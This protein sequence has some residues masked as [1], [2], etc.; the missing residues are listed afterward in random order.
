MIYSYKLYSAL[1]TIFNL[2]ITVFKLNR[3]LQTNIQ[4]ETIFLTFFTILRTCIFC[5]MKSTLHQKNNQTHNLYVFLHLILS[6]KLNSTY[7]YF[8]QNDI[9]L[10]NKDSIKTLKILLNYNFFLTVVPLLFDSLDG[11]AWPFWLSGLTCL[12]NSGNFKR[13]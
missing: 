13:H 10:T 12:V 1:K 5:F 3:V 11:G 9:W 8:T 7:L 2:K 4:N 6:H